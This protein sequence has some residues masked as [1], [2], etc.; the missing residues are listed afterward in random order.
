LIGVV[1]FSL[2]VQSE[3]FFKCG[4]GDCRLDGTEG[5]VFGAWLLITTALGFVGVGWVLAWV[6]KTICA[7][8]KGN[9]DQ[10]NKN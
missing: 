9:Y 2:A 4:G 1:A 5:F 6:A 8:C 3:Y 10:A 7:P